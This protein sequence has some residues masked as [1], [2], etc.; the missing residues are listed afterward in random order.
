[1]SAAIPSRLRRWLDFIERAGN[2]L[3]HPATL[4]AGLAALVVLISWAFDAVGVSVLHP[5]SGEVVH[6]VNLL[7]VSGL[8]RMVREV[9]RNFLAFRHSAFP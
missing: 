5:A 3:P 2:A 7:S 4:F 1:M 8:Q 9:A 6:T